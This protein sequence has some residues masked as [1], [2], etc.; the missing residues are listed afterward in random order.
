MSSNENDWGRNMNYCSAVPRDPVK[1]SKDT[2]YDRADFGFLTSGDAHCKGIGIDSPKGQT[3]ST[4]SA[5]VSR[6]VE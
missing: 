4:A 1:T 3:R 6:D 5:I 2:I